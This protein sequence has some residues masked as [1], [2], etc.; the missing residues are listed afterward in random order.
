MTE[1]ERLERLVRIEREL[2]RR[3]QACLLDR[4]RWLPG[5]YEFLRCTERIALFRAGSQITGKTYA[6]AAELIYRMR[7][8]HPLKAVRPGPIRAWVISGGG[9]N[10]AVC[11]EKVWELT[12]KDE[13][14]PGCEFDVRKGKFV[15]RYPQ[16]A[17]KNGSIALFKAGN[18]DASALES[19]SPD[20]VWIDEPPED[21]RTYD[22]LLK[23]LRA[24]NGDMRLSLTPA[25]VSRPLD[26]LEARSG[27]GRQIVDLHFPLTAENLV[28]V[29]TNERIRLKDGTPCDE[30][31]IAQLRR[32]TP[33]YEA[34]V[35]LDGEWEYRVEGNYFDKVWNKDVIVRARKD[36]ENRKDLRFVLGIDHGNRP[37]KQCAYLMSVEAL[38]DGD[39]SIH[40]WDEYVDWSGVATPDVD[41]RGILDMLARNGVA[42]S[43]L[44]Y[45]EGDKPHDQGRGSQK[46]NLDLAVIIT[47]LLGLPPGKLR[48]IIY[49]TK[50]GTGGSESQWPGVRWLHD[51]MAKRQFTI[52]PGCR[53]L[54]EAVPRFTGHPN[55]DAKDPVDAVRYAVKRIRY[56]RKRAP[57]TIYRIR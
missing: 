13:V 35:S 54:I 40:V 3:R 56:E 51:R 42:W 29:G 55:E 31:W 18:Q 53:R 7:G 5:Q 4:M 39:P 34:G 36:L 21:E 33:A 22:E 11:Q 45:V 47:R 38:A 8:R 9:E 49:T 52:D 19:G 14:M 15:G 25:D 2:E 23:R 24:T 32:D 41:A 28:F 17:F 43:E 46:S 20:Y 48:P 30:D 10:S 57:S 37:G 1:R 27:P 12:P 50:Q 26:W 16:L 44:A 6:G